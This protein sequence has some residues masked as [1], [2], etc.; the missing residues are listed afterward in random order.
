MRCEH[1]LTGIGN[2]HY[3]NDEPSSAQLLIVIAWHCH[4]AGNEAVLRA[5][6]E[7]AQFFYN[8]DRQHALESFRP[9][10]GTT[11]FQ[12]GLGS[13]LDKSER[14]ER[15]AGLLSG[16]TNQPSGTSLHPEFQVLIWLWL[17]C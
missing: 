15:L 2:D 5:R 13:M 17:R 16:L 1:A 4:C 10:L 14:V 7:D 8:K 3:R 9:Q 6:F 12:Q 11:T